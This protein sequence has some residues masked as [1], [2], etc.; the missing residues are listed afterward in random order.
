MPTHRA[1]YSQSDWR[2]ERR[3]GMNS[4][5]YTARRSPTKNTPG[6]CCYGP[7][8][9]SGVKG[10]AVPCDAIMKEFFPVAHSI[11][12]VI[13]RLSLHEYGLKYVTFSCGVDPMP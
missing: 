9:P 4:P 8:E 1:S 10:L 5:N 3:L 13:G 7:Y 6:S 11:G 2:D 12:I